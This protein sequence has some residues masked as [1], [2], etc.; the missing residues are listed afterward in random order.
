MTGTLL[1]VLIAIALI[2][3]AIVVLT[4]KRGKDGAVWPFYSKKPLSTPEQVLYHRLVKALPDCIVLAQVQLSRFLGVSKGRNFAQWNN[5][6]NRLSIDF[7]VCLKDSTVVA[8]IELDDSSHERSDRKDAD[9]RKERAITSAGIPLLR[10][11]VKDLP[12]ELAI[13][14][15]I[16]ERTG[17]PSREPRIAQ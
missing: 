12:D 17:S 15:A 3:L 2:A 10:W 13:Q 4:T 11:S 16:R 6:I 14:T 5:R 7:L 8:A 1:A 9:L